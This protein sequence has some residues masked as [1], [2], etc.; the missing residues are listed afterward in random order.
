MPS[1]IHD[2]IDRERAEALWDERISPRPRWECASCG[3]ENTDMRACWCA[4][5]QP[6]K[7]AAEVAA[8]HPNG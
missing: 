4:K 6:D 7:Y 1:V 8:G 3:Y 5:C 2:E